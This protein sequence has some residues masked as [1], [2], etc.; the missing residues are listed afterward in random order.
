MGAASQRG[1]ARQFGV[2]PSPLQYHLKQ[3]SKDEVLNMTA[4]GADMLDMDERRRA[5]HES[6]AAQEAESEE[7]QTTGTYL[8]TGVSFETYREAFTACLVK[9][10]VSGWMPAQ[11]SRLAL[12]SFGATISHKALGMY[13]P[14]NPDVTADNAHAH[15]VAFK[16]RQTS[17][18]T[19]R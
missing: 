4:L 8:D 2:H 13:I 17:L 1:I 18:P 11:A 9:I 12:D 7:A 19:S 3:L 14:W 6:E 5:H 16:G 10:K 15:K